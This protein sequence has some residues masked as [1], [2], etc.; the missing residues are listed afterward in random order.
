MSFIGGNQFKPPYTY[1]MF[2]IPLHEISPPKYW[3]CQNQQQNAFVFK[4]GTI[5]TN[6]LYMKIDDNC[7]VANLWLILIEHL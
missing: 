2:G 1:V 6:V 5:S 3:K 4:T 7:F